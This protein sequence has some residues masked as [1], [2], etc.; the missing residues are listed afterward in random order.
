MDEHLKQ[1]P[2]FTS[3]DKVQKKESNS[4]NFGYKRDFLL[5]SVQL[6]STD[7]QMMVSFRFGRSLCTFGL[8]LGFGF[9][10]V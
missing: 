6:G 3:K 7:Q 9:K 10:C 5:E 8:I 2:S 1:V 4:R